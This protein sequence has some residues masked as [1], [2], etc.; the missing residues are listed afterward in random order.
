MSISWK[1]F[2][3]SFF[4]DAA[5]AV[6]CF[7]LEIHIL[8]LTNPHKFHRNLRDTPGDLPLLVQFKY[9]FKKNDKELFL[10]LIVKLFVQIH[11]YFLWYFSHISLI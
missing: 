9:D 7:I 5:V 8:D 1:M 4:T 2:W 11:L 6:N 3:V 10:F